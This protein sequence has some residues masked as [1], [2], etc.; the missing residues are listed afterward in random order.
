M[1]LPYAT[2][3]RRTGN[4]VERVDTGDDPSKWNINLV[5][6]GPLISE[7]TMLDCVSYGANQRKG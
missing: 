2:Y 7:I 1:K 5:S 6:I 4:V 3:T